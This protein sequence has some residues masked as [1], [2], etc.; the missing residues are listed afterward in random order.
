MAAVEKII[1]NN[2]AFLTLSKW[3]MYRC[4]Y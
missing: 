2:T 4:G 3:I 1:D